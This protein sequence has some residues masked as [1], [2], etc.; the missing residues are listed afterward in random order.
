V[1][2]KLAGRMGCCGHA[3]IPFS[4]QSMTLCIIRLVLR[5]RLRPLILHSCPQIFTGI[6]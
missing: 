6:Q 2:E 4:H 3:A 1:T 5:S